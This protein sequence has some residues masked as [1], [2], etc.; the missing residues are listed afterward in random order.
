MQCAY[1]FATFSKQP[2]SMPQSLPASIDLAR[3]L[4]QL[5]LPQPIVANANAAAIPSP[6]IVFM[7]VSVS[8]F[9][10]C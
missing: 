5:A 7:L 4:S 10:L 3:K 9:P 1:F 8:C 2:K 6:K